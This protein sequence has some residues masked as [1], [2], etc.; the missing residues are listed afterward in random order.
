MTPRDDLRIG[1]AER[2]AVMT[3]LREHYAQG[4]LT[5]EELDERLGLTLSARTGRDLALAQENLPDL[6]GPPGEPAPWK[7]P[8]TG[9]AAWQRHAARHGAWHPMA[10]RGGP[11]V[12]PLLLVL[13]VAGVAVAGFGVLK[14]V[15]LAW[16]LAI[17]FRVLRH[18]SHARRAGRPGAP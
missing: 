4:R 18:R 12:A 16:L 2:D 7:G 14:L 15:F 17:L 13:L 3:A 10:R 5:H 9:P 6:Y 8:R 1:D 11:P